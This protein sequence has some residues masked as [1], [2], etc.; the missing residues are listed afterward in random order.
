MLVA[1]S[2]KDMVA[3]GSGA[4]KHTLTQRRTAQMTALVKPLCGF[5]NGPIAPDALH[6]TSN[7]CLMRNA[8]FEAKTETGQQVHCA[9]AARETVE[10][11]D[12]RATSK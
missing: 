4:F 8:L 2:G 1:A 7:T 10:S 12:L 3:P 6:R 9:W 5:P 11:S